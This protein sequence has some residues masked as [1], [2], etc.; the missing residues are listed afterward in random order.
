MGQIQTG[1]GIADATL[2]RTG[3]ETG[4]QSVPFQFSTTTNTTIWETID[5]TNELMGTVVIIGTDIGT[6]AT[7]G[8]LINGLNTIAVTD[9]ATFTRSV[10]QLNSITVTY[11][12]GAAGVASTLTLS[13]AANKLEL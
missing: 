6:G 8:V 2:N 11:D 10:D 5:L 12:S 9:N 3:R 7:M 1:I 4:F 13:L